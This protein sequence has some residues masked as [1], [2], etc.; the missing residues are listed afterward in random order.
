MNETT[1]TIETD[2]QGGRIV[3]VGDRYA[4]LCTDEC[5]WA[6]A[7]WLMGRKCGWLRT[8]E[9]HEEVMRHIRDMSVS[10]TEEKGSP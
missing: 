2:P 6:V 1:L 10:E 7:E 3:R 8:K 4:E 9:Q 5:L